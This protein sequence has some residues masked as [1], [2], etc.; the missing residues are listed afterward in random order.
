[1]SPKQV[2]TTGPRAARIRT[3]RKTAII[4]APP[5][6]VFLV[7]SL[8]F[9]SGG[10]VDTFGLIPIWLGALWSYILLHGAHYRPS[11]EH[12][13]IVD[14]GEEEDVV[15]QQRRSFV[16][17]TVVMLGDGVLAAGLF[18]FFVIQCVMAPGFLGVWSSMG[19]FI[20]L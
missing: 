5:V 12:D 11:R 15:R 17:A 7:L 9:N 16:K 6:S 20:I 2:I 19:V 3:A 14:D 1:M 13:K 10:A 4:L 18:S 8:T